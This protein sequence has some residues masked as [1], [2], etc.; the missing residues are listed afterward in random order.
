MNLK[1]I[2]LI[3]MLAFSGCLGLEKIP[4]TV[5]G[6]VTVYDAETGAL[7]TAATAYEF[8][9]GQDKFGFGTSFES[10]LEGAREGQTLTI[11]EAGPEFGSEPVV[12]PGVFGPLDLMG[13]IPQAQFEISFGPASAGSTFTPPGSFYDYRIESVREEIVTYIALPEDGQ[14]NFIEQLGANLVTDLNGDGTMT[15]S[16][17]PVLDSLFTVIPDAQGNTIL[18]LDPGTY[19][20][21]GGSKGEVHY[22]YTPV[23][24]E[25]IGKQLRYEVEILA[26]VSGFMPEPVEGNF[27]VRDSPVMLGPYV[28]GSNDG[29]NHDDHSH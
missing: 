22:L 27:G 6:E 3:S 9:I 20:T 18:G 24:P 13:T 12:V 15:Q 21:S 2:L 23:K 25:V 26:T 16:L 10:K 28:P 17:E 7:I 8:V 1:P 19:K 29:H 11:V 4:D 14:V 5:Y